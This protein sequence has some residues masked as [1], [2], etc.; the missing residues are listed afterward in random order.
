M[1][2]QNEKY[3]AHP[4]AS[5]Y[6]INA[7]IA[8]FITDLD[9]TSLRNIIRNDKFRWKDG[10]N[11]RNWSVI[12]GIVSTVNNINTNSVTATLPINTDLIQSMED[13]LEV[14]TKY[15]FV[16]ISKNSGAVKFSIV[17][18]NANQIF[19]LINP[20]EIDSASVSS[21]A[22][23][24]KTLFVLEFKT[25]STIMSGGINLKIENLN[26]GT[27]DL[28]IYSMYLHKG[29]IGFDDIQSNDVYGASYADLATN[30]L[31][32][33]FATNAATA[34]LALNSNLLEGYAI[35]AILE[36]I[37]S[38]L[39]YDGTKYYDTRGDYLGDALEINIPGQGTLYVPSSISPK[40]TCHTNCHHNCHSWDMCH[41]FT[42]TNEKE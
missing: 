16:A 23:T 19:N 29:V 34:D 37:P 24:D 36:L 30:S 1:T 42:S 4:L 18:D 12:G 13:V 35:S 40:G 22:V 28:E 39:M 15:T 9:E 3:T 17:S 8:K 14:D 26:I 11:I 27:I 2:S 20:T 21:V 41:M 5:P 10:T 25:N 33:N 31:S 7:N 6:A 32:A 38:S